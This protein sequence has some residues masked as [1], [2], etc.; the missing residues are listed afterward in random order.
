MLF[1][2]AAPIDRYRVLERFYRLDRRLIERFYAGRS[3]LADKVR[4]LAGKPP[5]PVGRAV[6]ALA[7]LG[8]PNRL[9]HGSL[10][11]EAA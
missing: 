10:R 9:R 3:T 7:G 2:A 1:G 11:A 6:A 4:I 8:E 5:V